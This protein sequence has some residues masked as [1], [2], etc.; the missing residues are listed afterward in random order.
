[1]TVS[2]SWGRGESEWTKKAIITT[3]QSERFPKTNHMTIACVAICFNHKLRPRNYYEELPFTEANLYP[4]RASLITRKH[5][6]SF[7]LG[8]GRTIANDLVGPYLVYQAILRFI[9]NI[10]IVCGS[11][12]TNQAI[13]CSE[14]IH[15]A[16]LKNLRCGRTIRMHSS[17]AIS[18]VN[19]VRHIA[20]CMFVRVID[21][22]NFSVPSLPLDFEI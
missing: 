13:L 8:L 2:Q 21:L 11:D 1:M 9:P 20:I 6:K 14:P 15:Q 10:L 3:E 5:V 7:G 22:R 17:T 12:L 18:V 19:V 4:G 16:I